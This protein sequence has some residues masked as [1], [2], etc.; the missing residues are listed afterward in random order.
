[1][2]HLKGMYLAKQHEAQLPEV[3]D[4]RQQ[5]ALNYANR[6][7]RDYFEHVKKYGY[8]NCCHIPRHH[9]EEISL[10]TEIVE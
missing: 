7:R 8:E 9:G 6:M 10:L 2:G 3:S 4:D 5:R 1:M